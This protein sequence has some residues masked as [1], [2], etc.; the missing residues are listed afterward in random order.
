MKRI[1]ALFMAVVLTVGFLPSAAFAAEG[2]GPMVVATADKSTIKP[3]ET[4]TITYTLDHDLDY[5][6]RLDLVLKYDATLFQFVSTDIEG[7]VWFNEPAQNGP[8]G[9]GTNA[10]VR[11]RENNDDNEDTISAGKLCSITF[12][13]LD[14]IDSA[15]TASFYNG[16][17]GIARSS[18]VVDEDTYRVSDGAFDHG[19]DDPIQVTIAPDGAT[20][21]PTATGYSV[22][23][24]AN[25]QAVGGQKVRIPVT[26]A[27]SEKGITGFNAYDMTFTYDP[28]ALTLNTTSDSAANLTV[29]DNNGTVRVRRYGDTVALGEALALDFTA[30]KAGTSTVTL[31]AAKFDLDANSINFDAPSA[32]I[33]DADTTVKALWNVSLP[34][35]FVSAAADGSTLVEDGADFT[36]KAVDPN[37]EYTLR[38]T[39]N[40]QTQEVTVKGGSCTIEN[41]TDNVQ[42]TMVSKVGRTYTLKFIG[43]GV[44]AGLVTPTT[45]TVQYPNDYDFTVKF[46]GTGYK[47]TVS[48]APSANKFDVERLENGDYAYKLLGNYL[49]GDENGEITVTVEKVENTAKKDIIVA[50]SGSEAFSADNALTFYAGEN[51]TF[52][53]DKN[54]QYYDYE[55]VVW[56]TDS[57]N[58]TVRPT[59][60]DNGDG[61]YTIVN[62][63]NADMHITINKMAK[64][65]DPDAVDVVKYLELDNKTMYMVTVWGELSHT[66]LGS[67]NT[68]YIAYTYDDNLMYDTSYYTAPNGTKGASSWLVIVDK[69]EEFTKEEVLKHLK[70][71]ESTQEQNKNISLVYFGIDP[72]VNGSK[73]GQLDINDV[74]LVYDM[75]NSLYENFEQVSVKKFL[76]ADQT[77]DRQLN[78]A[79]AVKLADKLG[80]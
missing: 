52:K 21:I 67:T 72:N 34:D 49:V 2:D 57:S 69:G 66:N 42:V 48:F 3:G 36:F 10:T 8:L 25:Q 13:A 23:M 28:A 38:I 68:T 65:L 56:Y 16:T 37:Y 20:P 43:S 80:Y 77:L 22:S 5:M 51:Y 75:Y 32:T 35:G 14:S 63:P 24:G 26:V 7:S 27:S 59:P 45:A 54:E 19:A 60:K 12:T 31:T 40:G 61:T 79:D 47:T 64:A 6:T 76:L 33:T 39:T 4:L 17:T 50:G 62:M 44:D 29:E 73:G 15:Q 11:I 74:Q 18:I 70:L 46:P 53:L 58:H 55:L 71:V 78:S 30:K 9:S 41:V 1:L